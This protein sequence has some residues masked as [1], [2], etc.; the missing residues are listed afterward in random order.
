MSPVLLTY[1][2]YSKHL[3]SFNF[4]LFSIMLPSTFD[5]IILLD[6]LNNKLIASILQNQHNACFIFQ[7]LKKKVL[8]NKVTILQMSLEIVQATSFSD[9]K[10]KKKPLDPMFSGLSFGRLQ[11][12]FP[13]HLPS[14]LGHCT[15][16]KKS[17]NT[18]VVLIQS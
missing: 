5:I 7:L 11:T 6:T 13:K 17:P 4:F 16:R 18:Q 2:H 10:E 15:E 1:H 8:K 14:Q 9:K 12:Q 3:D